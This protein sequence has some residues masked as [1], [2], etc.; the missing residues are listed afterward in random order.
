MFVQMTLA[1]LSS[2]PKDRLGPETRVKKKKRKMF[3]QMTSCLSGLALLRAL[4]NSTKLERE[5][6]EEGD[7]SSRG[8]SNLA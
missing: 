1:T 7:W 4:T 6:A 2:R 8:R 3:L 5:K